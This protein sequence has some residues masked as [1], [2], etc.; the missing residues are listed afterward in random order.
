MDIFPPHSPAGP[1]RTLVGSTT[2]HSAVL[3][4]VLH[5]D[6]LHL[7]LHFCSGTYTLAQA[8]VWDEAACW[9]QH[10]AVFPE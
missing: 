3:F 4:P 5:P 2:L 9:P 8:F 1:S 7:A 6:P 10:P